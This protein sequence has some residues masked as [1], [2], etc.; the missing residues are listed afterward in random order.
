MTTAYEIPLSPEAQTFAA[1]LGSTEYNMTFMFSAIVGAWLLSIADSNS[2]P[3]LASIPL[4]PGV[5]LF[6]QFAYLKLGGALY[7]VNDLASTAP[8]RY[9]E[10]GI[11]GHVYFV[12]P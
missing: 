5:D 3:I 2:V 10:L 7:V 8:P 9:E 4:I 12:T 6:A 11:T 1:K